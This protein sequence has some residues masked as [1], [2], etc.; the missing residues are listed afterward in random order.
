MPEKHN[1]NLELIIFSIPER[2]E[3]GLS[4]PFCSIPARIP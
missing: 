1:S 3:F 2:K 4:V